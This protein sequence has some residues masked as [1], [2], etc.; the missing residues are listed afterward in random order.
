MV[1]GAGALGTT[2]T[3]ILR[4]LHPDVE[5]LTVARWPAQAE[6]A[7]RLGAKVVAP[8]PREA[9]VEEIASWSGGMLRRA[10]AGLPMVGGQRRCR[11]RLHALQDPR[12]LCAPFTWAC[13]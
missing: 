11:W 13:H 8:E 1:Y 10:W 3:A 7:A 9:L 4:C 5:V 2:T 6:L 12:K